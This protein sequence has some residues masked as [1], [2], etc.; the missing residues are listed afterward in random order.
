[1]FDFRKLK[2]GS[3]FFQILHSGGRRTKRVK[4]EIVLSFI[5]KFFS[6]AI[7]ILLVPLTIDYLDKE[8]YGVWLTLTSVFSWFSFFDIGLGNGMRNKV[9]AAISNNDA[10]L[11]KEYISTTYASLALIFI[12]IIIAFQVINPFV[13]WQSVL[14]TT[15]I[16]VK[17]LYLVT[18]V[19]FTLFLLRFIF[20]VI[21]IIYIALQRPSVNNALNT[22]GNLAA[23]ILILFLFKIS[24][25]GDL[26][27]LGI[28][29][30]GI[31]LIVFIIASFIAFSG[32]LKHL[33]PDLKSV[34]SFHVKDLLNLGFKFFIIQ[35]A[36]VL[37]FSSAN[38]IIS[39]LF[40]PNEVVVYNTAL[41]YYQVPIMVEGI[42]MMPIWSAV[43][44]AYARGDLNWLRS[45]I[46]KL[47]IV[48]CIMAVFIIGMTLISPL[49]YKLWM[50]DRV[51]I[52]YSLSIM[53]AAYATINIFLAP[54]TS[55]I[56]GIGKMKLSVRLVI[57]TLLF[58][59]PLAIL[60]A[61]LF[62]NSAGIMCAICL[63]NITGLY[64]QPKQLNK[65]LNGTA[66]GIWNE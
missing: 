30:T 33:R 51:F 5:I 43:T 58:Y 34:R 13:S 15:S 26:L 23:F 9:A 60:F 46:N 2:S 4:R 29:L 64:F 6:L 20:Q 56:N 14:N 42:I 61:K 27:S 41:K 62:G 47:N 28:I 45:A 19:V 7:T 17:E 18:S 37:L 11:A 44:E 57:I 3:K 49:V 59:V 48:S 31:P 16:S 35:I 39:Q 12:F 8:R 52:P 54:Y 36:A 53:M 24:K 21:G 25:E 38:V 10:N 40:S 66:K 55:F 1:M 22:L 50:G 65:I 32:Q 63:L